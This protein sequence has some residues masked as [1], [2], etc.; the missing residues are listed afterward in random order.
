[1]VPLGKAPNTEVKVQLMTMQLQKNPKKGKS[2]FV[3]TITC[4]KEKNGAKKSLPQCPKK[5]PRG[6]NIVRPKRPPRRLHPRKEVDREAELEEM[7]KQL[8]ELCK[9]IHRVNGLLVAHTRRQD[10]IMDEM[11]MRR[12]RRINRWG[13]SVTSSHILGKFCIHKRRKGLQLWRG[14]RRTLEPSRL[15]K[16]T[17]EFLRIPQNTLDLFGRV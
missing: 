7:T 8:R 10:S 13:E 12:D 3:A 17:R 5:V 1:M 2:T 16:K 4:S 6:N 9:G 11:T 15:I 14:L